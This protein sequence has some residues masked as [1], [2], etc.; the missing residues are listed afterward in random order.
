MLTSYSASGGAVPSTEASVDYRNWLEARTSLEKAGRKLSHGRFFFGGE[1]VT[2][3]YAIAQP[4][5][6]SD[7]K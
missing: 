2:C 6:K 1:P 7:L 3:Q 4:E 5:Q